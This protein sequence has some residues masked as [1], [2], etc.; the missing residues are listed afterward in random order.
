MDILHG[1]EAVLHRS[2]VG[3][4]RGKAIVNGECLDADV[5]DQ[6]VQHGVVV[7]GAH[8]GPAAA[9]DKNQGAGGPQLG[10]T[11]AA[12]TD[13][14]HILVVDLKILQFT[15]YSTRLPS[16]REAVEKARRR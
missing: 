13:S 7:V 10:G 3:M 4:L 9:V 12:D 6:P 2:G 1:S 15:E 16:C 5:R 8:G 14:S 11:V